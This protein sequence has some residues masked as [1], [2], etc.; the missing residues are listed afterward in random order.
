ML[1]FSLVASSASQSNDRPI[2]WEANL[3]PSLWPVNTS[4]LDITE[5]CFLWNCC[6]RNSNLKKLKAKENKTKC[7]FVKCYTRR[8]YL[9]ILNKKKNIRE[10][11]GQLLFLV[12]NTAFPVPHFQSPQSNTYVSSPQHPK[13]KFFS[14]F[15]YHFYTAIWTYNRIRTCCFL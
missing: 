7:T 5:C 11:K 12:K 14:Y 1:L 9:P 10:E 13:S 2:P 3:W 15:P 8:H 6:S 4:K